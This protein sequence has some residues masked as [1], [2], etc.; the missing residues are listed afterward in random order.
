MN[1]IKV[2]QED[3]WSGKRGCG[4]SCAVARAVRRE[5]NKMGLSPY[6]ESDGSIFLYKESNKINTS[7]KNPHDYYLEILDD[8]ELADVQSFIYNFDEASITKPIQFRV[9]LVEEIN[10]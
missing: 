1:T 9:E 8:G 4:R 7:F 2:T 10:K 6:V 5:F 3:I